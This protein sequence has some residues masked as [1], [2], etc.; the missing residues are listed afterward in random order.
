[1]AD[2]FFGRML[3][4]RLDLMN[5]IIPLEREHGV[6]Y[7]DSFPADLGTRQGQMLAKEHAYRFLEELV[8]EVLDARTVEDRQ[9]ELTDAFLFFLSFCVVVGVKPHT[10]YWQGKTEFS[11]T[12]LHGIVAATGNLLMGATN[13][14]KARPWRRVFDEPNSSDFE[15]RVQLAGNLLWKCFRASGVTSL[16]RL[17]ELYLEKHNSALQRLATGY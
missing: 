6:W 16:E 8:G 3:N 5:Q 14:L 7:P 1:M 9:G 17:E 13:M 12:D 10:H 11:S 15:D 2:D 4:L